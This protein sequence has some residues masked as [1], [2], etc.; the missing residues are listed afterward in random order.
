MTE[1]GLVRMWRCRA[2]GER[3]LDFTQLNQCGDD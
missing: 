2:P 1:A 3:Q